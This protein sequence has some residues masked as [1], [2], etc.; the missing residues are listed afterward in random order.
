MLEKATEMGVSAFY[1]FISKNS[2]RRRI[3]QDRLERVVLSAAKQSLKG[4]VPVVH[5]LQKFDE[6]IKQPFQGQKF[7]AHCSDLEK[8]SFTKSITTNL[9]VMMCIGPEGDFSDDEI[10]R[11]IKANFKPVSL[12]N[13]RLRTETAGVVAVSVLY[14]LTA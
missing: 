8:H 3:R 14:N 9:P 12:G 5:E 11:A 4:Q 7:I 13:S 10:A 2:E 6:V 1:P